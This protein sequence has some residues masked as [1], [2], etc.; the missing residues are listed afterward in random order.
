[1]LGVA[2]LGSV[3]VFAA[4][5]VPARAGGVDA[6]LHTNELTMHRIAAALGADRSLG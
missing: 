1:V 2:S 3:F 4:C 5:A 6:N